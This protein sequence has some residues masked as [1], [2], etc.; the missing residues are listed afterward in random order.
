VVGGTPEALIPVAR[1]VLSVHCWGVNGTPS[2]KDGN[3]N[4]AW[5][6]SNKPPWNRTAQ[7]AEQIRAAALRT[8]YDGGLTKQVPMLAG[9]YAHAYVHAA[10]L[11]T[12]PRRIPG[13][14]ASY[15]HF[16]FD[17]QL[18]WTPEAI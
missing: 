11:L 5:S 14:V 4:P 1:P 8:S 6:W 13:D 16:Q 9:G 7:L 10:Y 17:L 12:E 15:A 3:P 18:V 2:Y